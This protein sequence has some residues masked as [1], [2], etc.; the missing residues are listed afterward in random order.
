[1]QILSGK[2][3]YF[4][5]HEHD[6]YAIWFTLPLQYHRGELRDFRI[7]K[8]GGFLSK[9]LDSG[10]TF[11]GISVNTDPIGM[12]FEAE[13]PGKMKVTCTSLATFRQISG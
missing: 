1:M 5:H 9:P 10:K 2:C 6:Y 4:I 3:V 13:N 12:R 11:F 7:L 8:K